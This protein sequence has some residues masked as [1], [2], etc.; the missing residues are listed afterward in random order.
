[1]EIGQRQFDDAGDGIV[2]KRFGKNVVTSAPNQF[3]PQVIIRDAGHQDDA[4]VVRGGRQ[5]LDGGSPIRSGPI[6]IE[7]NDGRVPLVRE[8]EC[9]FTR[10][11][12]VHVKGLLF[13]N[14]GQDAAILFA[15]D[16]S[17]NGD[18]RCKSLPG[19]PD[20]S[21]ERMQ[22]LPDARPSNIAALTV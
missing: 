1:M 11:R 14:A 4:S 18:T 21:E 16:Q 13:G 6:A 8:C 9:F 10:L 7:E 17:H 15:D 19:R 22:S 5:A 20:S 12:E 2:S 3:L